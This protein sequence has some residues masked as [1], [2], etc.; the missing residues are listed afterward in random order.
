MDY[1]DRAEQRAAL[2]AGLDRVARR[3][4]ADGDRVPAEA[5]RAERRDVEGRE[6]EELR[7]RPIEGRLARIFGIAPD[8]A[9]LPELGALF[10]A[11]WLERAAPFPDAV[12]L[13]RTLRARGVPVVIVSNTPWGTAPAAWRREVARWEL[14]RWTAASVFCGDVGWRKPD[15]RIFAAGL[16]AAGGGPPGDVLF[17]GDDPRWDLVGP[18][19]IGMPA[20]LLDRAGSAGSRPD[21]IRSLAEVAARFP[22]PD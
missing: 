2:T 8:D 18:R 4:T 14:D 16:A 21:V 12:P 5:V 3:L 15:A 19:A 7:V 13:L 1:G 11:P 9:R 17:V 6:S 22:R 20:L 10:L